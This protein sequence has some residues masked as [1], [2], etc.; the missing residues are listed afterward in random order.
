MLLRAKCVV[1]L[2]HLINTSENTTMHMIKQSFLAT[3]SS[4][5]Y[6]RIYVTGVKMRRRLAQI[7]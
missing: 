4:L 7:H 5:T 3:L 1:N 2:K 6:N